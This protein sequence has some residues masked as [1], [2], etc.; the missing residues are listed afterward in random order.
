MCKIFKSISI[1][2]Q[3]E[4]SN[5]VVCVHT[6][7][8]VRAFCKSLEDFMTI[9]LLTEHHLEFLSLKRNYTGTSEC[10]LVKMP[11]CWKS[12][13]IAHLKIEI[14]FFNL[15]NVIKA[16]GGA[17]ISSRSKRFIEKSSDDHYL[18]HTM[19]GCKLNYNHFIYT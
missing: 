16:V 10:T 7:S 5:N 19:E 3:H 8:L 12:H 9:K 14:F 11:H 2:P 13:S 6:R 18:H 17:K 1:E 15:Q 4:I